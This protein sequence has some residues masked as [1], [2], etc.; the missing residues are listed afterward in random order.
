MIIVAYSPRNSSDAALP[1]GLVLAML[2][3]GLVA[4]FVMPILAGH[5]RGTS[6][7]GNG[8][9]GPDQAGPAAFAWSYLEC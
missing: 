6:H 3:T 7:L 2:L 9:D 8:A 4:P 1:R 5:G